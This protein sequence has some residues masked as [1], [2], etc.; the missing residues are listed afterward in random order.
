MAR[1]GGGRKSARGGAGARTGKRPKRG[2][3]KRA[4]G[5]DRD[6]LLTLV[7]IGEMTGISYP[8]LLR[9]VRL[10]LDRLPHTGSGRKRR[11]RPGAVEEFQKLRG[12]SRRGRRAARPS[13]VAPSLARQLAK[14][15]R[16]Q[17]S[18][19]RQIRDLRKTLARP[20]RVRLE[21]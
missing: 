20:V 3:G 18:L 21:R 16:G 6:S 1:R 8:T 13:A 14:L 4:Q 12:E 17:R 2:A 9:Y 10:H 7:Q 15:E 5:G 11:F 19:V